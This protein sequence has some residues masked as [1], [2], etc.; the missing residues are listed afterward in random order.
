MN[1]HLGC[2][3]TFNLTLFV[4]SIFSIAAGG[5][6][7]FFGLASLLAVSSAGVGGNLPV[8]SAVFLGLRQSRCAAMRSNVTV[9]FVPG[10]HQYLLTVL[11]IWWAIGQ[12]LVSL[13]FTLSF[14][15]FFREN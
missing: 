11:S 5:A 15:C 14:V 4:G 1:A 13:V 12:L 7:T 9:E 8:D 6:P 3:W 2:R 10:S